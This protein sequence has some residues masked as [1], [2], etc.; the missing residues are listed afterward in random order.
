MQ[1]VVGTA[2]AIFLYSAFASLLG[3]FYF[4]QHL[5]PK[6]FGFIKANLTA[7]ETAYGS[8]LP[9]PRICPTRNGFMRISGDSGNAFATIWEPGKAS[10]S[11]AAWQERQEK[12]E[13]GEKPKP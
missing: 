7:P 9:T 12:E 3:G 4:V 6:I 8:R 11:F 10:G 2:T 1:Y 13:Q 5:V